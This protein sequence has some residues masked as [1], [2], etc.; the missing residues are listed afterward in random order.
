MGVL[1]L[2]GFFLSS[3]YN[4]LDPTWVRDSTAGVRKSLGLAK[5]TGTQFEPDTDRV[6]TRP[7]G[8]W[9]GAAVHFFKVVLGRRVLGIAL[10]FLVTLGLIATLARRET[11]WYG[12]LVLIPSLFFFLAAITVAAYHVQPR[13]LCALYP[14]LATLA[15]PGA[16]ALLGPFRM[17]EPRRRQAAVAL[18]A[19]ASLPTLAEAVRSTGSSP[20][21]TAGSSPT[22][23]STRTSRREPG[24]WWTTTG[25]S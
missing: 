2:A 25:R 9:G 21:R 12:L 6:Q 23:G 19:L 16:L 24:S 22:S 3:P 15:W 5:E 10:S 17:P 20:S 13:H 18:A 8:R 7:R 1:F 4:F 14:L 11:R